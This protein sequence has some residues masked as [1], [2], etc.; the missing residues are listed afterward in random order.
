MNPYILALWE[1]LCPQS[2]PYRMCWY[3]ELMA[4]F[5]VSNIHSMVSL[6]VCPKEFS[7]N[8]R[9]K[10]T[11]LWHTVLHHDMKTQLKY[12]QSDLFLLSSEL[13]LFHSLLSHIK[14][15]ISP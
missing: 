9:N 4:V 2:S 3:S 12:T 7:P 5:I 11:K 13:L 1:T 15:D 6:M 8:T 10:T 14:P